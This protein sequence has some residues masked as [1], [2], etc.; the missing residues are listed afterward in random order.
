LKR[1]IVISAEYASR[2]ISHHGIVYPYSTKSMSSR[3]ASFRGPST[4]NASPVSKPKQPN[5]PSSPSRGPVESPYHRKLRSALLELRSCART[6]DDLVLH[7]G[8]KAAR[9]LVDARTELEYVVRSTRVLKLNEPV[10][11]EVMPSPSCHRGI[12]PN[13]ALLVLSFK[14]WRRVYPSSMP[15]S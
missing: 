1:G 2:T 8:L 15:L 7:D 13:L 12:S 14:S 5:S 9:T 6:W 3:L 10:H 11:F 4:P